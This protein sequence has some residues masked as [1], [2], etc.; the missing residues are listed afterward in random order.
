MDGVLAPVAFASPVREW[1]LTFKYPRT[2]LF[3]QDAAITGLVLWLAR[4]AAEGF[5]GSL[6]DCITP[7]PCHPRRFRK[8]GFEPAYRLALEIA[9]HRG[10][11]LEPRLLR[12]VRH[13]PTQ[14]GLSAREREAN[15]EGAF[16]CQSRYLP[17]KACIWLVDDVVTTGATLRSAAQALKQAGAAKVMGLC[18]ARTGT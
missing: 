10:L 14:T 18:I 7:V 6:P 4:A 8:R 5:E 3:A 15:V 16:D 2:G 12:R 11:P 13:T 1:I 9:R 17:H